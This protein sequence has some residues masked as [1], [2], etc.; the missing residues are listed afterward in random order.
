MVLLKCNF[1]LLKTIYTFII[2]CRNVP[3]VFG[4][5]QD[6]YLP[7]IKQMF[8]SSLLYGSNGSVRTAAVRAY[9]AF[10]CENEEDN[11]VIRSLS[12]QIPAVIQVNWMFFLVV[13]CNLR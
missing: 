11:R 1:L 13:F 12:D 2:C 7:G 8:Q 9:V 5:D 6:R 4:C 10:M 3:S